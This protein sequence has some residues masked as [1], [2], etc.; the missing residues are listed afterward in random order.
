MASATFPGPWGAHSTPGMGAAS[1]PPAFLT[2][3]R[4]APG[5]LTCVLGQVE[6]RGIK[7][8]GMSEQPGRPP[9]PAPQ[10]PAVCTGFPC[11]LALSLTEPS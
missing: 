5:L 3:G 4:E 8:V 10:S 9:P 6:P 2:Q 11:S 7:G 1:Q